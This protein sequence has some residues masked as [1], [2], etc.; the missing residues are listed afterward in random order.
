M[1]TLITAKI[2]KT[3]Q[4]TRSFTLYRIS[5]MTAKR[6][7]LKQNIRV[8][9]CTTQIIQIVP[10]YRKIAHS[11]YIEVKKLIRTLIREWDE[12][13]KIHLI[14][15]FPKT[16]RPSLP[17]RLFLADFVYIAS[18]CLPNARTDTYAGKTNQPLINENEEINDTNRT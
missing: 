3:Y 9:Q 14:G 7:L 11:L 13:R 8:I 12:W 4:Y 16:I 17:K 6:T 10:R 2:P 18:Y 1:V 15:N 5:S